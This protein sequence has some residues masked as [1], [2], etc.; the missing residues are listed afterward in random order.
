MMR[1]HWDGDR[2]LFERDVFRSWMIALNRRGG[3]VLLDALPEESLI[4]LLHEEAFLAL[5]W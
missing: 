1:E 3:V 2:S 4:K 5:G